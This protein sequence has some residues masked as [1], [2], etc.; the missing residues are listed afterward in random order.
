MRNTYYNIVLWICFIGVPVAVSLPS[1]YG[2]CWE[3]CGTDVVPVTSDMEAICVNDTANCTYCMFHPKCCPERVECIGVWGLS[4]TPDGKCLVC[5][6][7]ECVY[8]GHAYYVGDTFESLD[9]VN[10]CTCNADGRI[11]CGI[12]P[13][14][15]PDVFCSV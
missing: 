1:P 8:N 3:F 7:Q 5:P 13:L 2:E 9:N 14:P 12:E 6:D 10:M 15:T 4:P 11:S